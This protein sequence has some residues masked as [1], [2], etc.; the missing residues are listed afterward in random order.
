M[1]FYG[2]EEFLKL[3]HPVSN[4]DVEE[5]LGRDLAGRSVIAFYR[6]NNFLDRTR[7]KILVDKVISNIL[8]NNNT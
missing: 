4:I 6:K 3:A 7:R 2:E 1:Y 5:L 8:V